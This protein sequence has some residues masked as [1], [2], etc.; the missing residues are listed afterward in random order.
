MTDTKRVMVKCECEGTGFT[1]VADSGGDGVDYVECAEHNPAF[2]GP[3]V[4][5]LLSHIGKRTGITSELFKP[6][7]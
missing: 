4:G 2:R 6:H 1:A 3:N 5:E 7:N